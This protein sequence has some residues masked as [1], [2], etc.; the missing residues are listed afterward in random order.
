[1]QCIYWSQPVNVARVYNFEVSPTHTLK[2]QVISQKNVWRTV[3]VMMV[4]VVVVVIVV[5]VVVDRK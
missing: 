4:V 5:V 2:L 1:M 3:V